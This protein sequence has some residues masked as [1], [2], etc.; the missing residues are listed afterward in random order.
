[1][2]LDYDDCIKILTV[3]LRLRK[4]C[5]MSTVYK[6]CMHDL[7]YF[8]IFVNNEKKILFVMIFLR[9]ENV[10]TLK[11]HFVILNCNKRDRK[12]HSHVQNTALFGY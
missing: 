3:Q 5:Y 6:A 4:L 2:F 11:E 1:M 7:F 9:F 8:V 12:Q 10:I